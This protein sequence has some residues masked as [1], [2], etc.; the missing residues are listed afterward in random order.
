M[1]RDHR[2]GPDIGKRAQTL[3]AAPGKNNSLPGSRRC[4]VGMASVQITKAAQ[5]SRGDLAM[6]WQSPIGGNPLSLRARESR[7]SIANSIANFVANLVTASSDEQTPPFHH[8]PFREKLAT[9]PQM[10]AGLSRHSNS[11][12]IL[13]PTEFVFAT[14]LKTCKDKFTV[15]NPL[16]CKDNTTTVFVFATRTIS[17]RLSQFNC[18]AS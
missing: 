3:P 12:P 5:P 15:P 14:S 17:P 11:P 16:S 1:D 8:F 6:Q 2:L 9:I 18:S 7:N 4:C 10:K 13:F